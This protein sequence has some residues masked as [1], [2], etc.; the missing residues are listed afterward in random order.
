MGSPPLTLERQIFG[1]AI[2]ESNGITPAH[3]GK[4][5]CTATADKLCRDHPRLRRNDILP[6]FLSTSNIGS[7]P[8]TRE[9]HSSA[10]SGSIFSR[11]TPAY[12]GTTDIMSFLGSAAGDHP[13][14]RGNDALS[15]I[16]NKRTL[17]SPPLARERPLRFLDR[18]GIYRITP[19]DAGKTYARTPTI[20]VGWD[21]PR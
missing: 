16:E 18:V 6:L 9:R 3:A 19:A 1:M 20:R 15:R 13:R 2:D 10:S 8:L 17:G 11:I 5:R 14:L 21:H 12:A 7:P 4:T